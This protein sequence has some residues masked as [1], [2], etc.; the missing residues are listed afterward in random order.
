[1]RTR[2]A[3]SHP[4]ETTRT[5]TGGPSGWGAEFTHEQLARVCQSWLDGAK[6]RLDAV[7]ADGQAAQQDA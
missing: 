5:P 1:M 2:A 4:P 3:F 6:A 7:L